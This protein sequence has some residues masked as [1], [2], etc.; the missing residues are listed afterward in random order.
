MTFSAYYDKTRGVGDET[1][2]QPPNQQNRNLAGYNSIVITHGKK[3]LA[4]T[5]PHLSVPRDP[6]R[7]MAVIIQ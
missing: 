2:Y 6:S 7:A 1:F 5:I 4:Q 3:G